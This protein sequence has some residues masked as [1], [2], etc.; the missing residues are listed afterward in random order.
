MKVLAL[1]PLFISAAYSAVTAEEVLNMTAGILIGACDQEHLDFLSA[2]ISDTGRIG[3]DLYD[4]V[5]L[6][7]EGDFESVRQGLGY[8]GDAME[9]IAD[10][11]YQ[12]PQAGA[13]DIPK[14]A[15]MAQIFKS[16]LDLVV[17]VGKDILVNKKSIKSDI[18]GGI[19]AFN[20]GSYLESGEDFG[21]AAALVLFG[22]N[23]N[24][25]DTLSEDAYNAYLVLGAFASNLVGGASD[26]VLQDMY[27]AA[28][29]YGEDFFVGL[30]KAF[31]GKTTIASAS[32]AAFFLHQ[33]AF[34][35]N[36]A[37][38]QMQ[39]DA[40]LFQGRD[41]TQYTA[42]L[43]NIQAAQI[44][45]DMYT[46]INASIQAFTIAEYSSIG[47]YVAASTQLCQHAPTTFA[48]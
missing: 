42:C 9:A 47:M 22:R 4:A 7:I 27:N 35:F 25:I 15:E 23:A 46:Y 16:P 26:S 43:K 11:L 34:V 10:D 48:Q 14:L 24:D 39:K 40:G 30:T 6:F 18:Q 45:T 17:Q 31:T 5:E 19:D 37:G 2:C 29:I 1:L 3:Y 21:K 36:Y 41:L 32:D 13:V 33:L 44:S 8:V 20:A 12:C 38:N 28:D